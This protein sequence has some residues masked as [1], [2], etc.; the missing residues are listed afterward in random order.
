MTRA[1][2]DLSHAIGTGR[3]TISW[4]VI[5]ADTHVVHGVVAFGVGV[6]PNEPEAEPASPYDPA[7]PL[8]SLLRLLQ[9]A[10]ALVACGALAFEAA[11]ARGAG[12]DLTRARARCRNL[13]SYSALLAIA[14]SVPALVVQALAA[15][16]GAFDTLPTAVAA[17]VLGSQ[18]GYA[19]VVRAI[20]LAAIVAIRLRAGMLADRVR[21]LASIAALGAF[22]LSGHALAVAS[23]RLGAANVVADLLHVGGAAVWVGGIV[24]FVAVQPLVPMRAAIVAFSPLAV[25]AVL[26]IVLSGMYAAVVH[27][28]SPHAL[29]T[30]AYGIV[31]V[32]KIALLVPLLA[33]GARNL[34]RGRMLVSL[35]GGVRE[36]RFEAV[37]AL[38]LVALSALLTGLPPAREAAHAT[39]LASQR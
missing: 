21:L 3:Y 10:G 5:S 32:A 38:A 14:A 35:R 36:I 6:A 26:S 29:A 25:A 31:L 17:T 37:L 16:G 7:A 9:L 23:P 1:V 8:A 15:N 27:V 33:L 20:A 13:A 34:M 39:A 28:G 11:A 12:D 22:S 18:W 2:C 24:A 19:W 4:R 30:T